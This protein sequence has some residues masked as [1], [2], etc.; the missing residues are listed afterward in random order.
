MTLG[1][2]LNEVKGD[3]ALGTIKGSNFLCIARA[4][5]IRKNF[6]ELLDKEVLESYSRLTDGATAIIIDGNERGK[7]WTK[8]EYKRA[9][10]RYTERDTDALDVA[11]LRG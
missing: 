3:I 2:K 8:E 6:G 7:W 10:P 1:E 4:G 9:K 5:H 11:T